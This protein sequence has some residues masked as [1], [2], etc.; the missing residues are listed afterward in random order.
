MLA[1]ASPFPFPGSKGFVLGTCDPVTIIRKND[2]GTAL[3]RRDPR[4]HEIRNRDASGNATMPMADIFETESEAFDASMKAKPKPRRKK[5][6][7]GRVSK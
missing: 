4:P 1:T 7:T 3:V 5:A 6:R 2:D